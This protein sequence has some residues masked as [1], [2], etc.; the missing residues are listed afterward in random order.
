MREVA[1]GILWIR[2]ALPFALN[3]INLWLIADGDGW[4][5]VDTGYNTDETRGYWDS[6]FATALDGKPIR[7]IVVTHFHPD[8][9]SGRKI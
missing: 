8:H 5:A 6:V 2:M 4:T 1:P 9:I 7:R 3:H